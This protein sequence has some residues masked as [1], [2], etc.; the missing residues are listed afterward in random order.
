MEEKKVSKQKTLFNLSLCVAAV[1]AL[2][3]TAGSGYAEM[4][5]TAVIVNAASNYSSGA[6][7]VVSVDPVGGPRTVQ[8]DPEPFR[9]TCLPQNLILPLWLTDTISTASDAIRWIT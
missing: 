3:M 4:T 1:L 5:Q 7:S 8:N 9:M 2:L 6:H